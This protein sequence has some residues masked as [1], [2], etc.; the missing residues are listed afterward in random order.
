MR[1]ETEV[2]KRS[3]IA[4]SHVLVKKYGFMISGR[5]AVIENTRPWSHVKR[6]IIN[7]SVTCSHFNLIQWK[8]TT[9]TLC[10]INH[11]WWHSMLVTLRDLMTQTVGH[12]RCYDNPAVWSFSVPKP[13]LS[14][15]NKIVVPVVCNTTVNC[16]TSVLVSLPVTFKFFVKIIYVLRERINNACDLLVHY[17]AFFWNI[18]YKMHY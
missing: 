14:S 7:Q 9:P 16:V 1:F 4:W 6:H 11:F 10:V 17:C 15:S 8:Y 13:I 3:S 5:Q 12:I 2:P 18:D